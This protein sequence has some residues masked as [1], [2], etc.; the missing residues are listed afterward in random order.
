TMVGL[1][2]LA[3]LL[4]GVELVLVAR[5]ADL[6]RHEQQIQQILKEK[7][8]LA[9]DYARLLQGAGSGKSYIEHYSDFLRSIGQDPITLMAQVPSPVPSEDIPVY[10]VP[11][12]LPTGMPPIPT[13][14]TATPTVVSVPITVAWGA[15]L[16]IDQ[17]PVAV[18]PY[19][20]F[21]LDT[22]TPDARF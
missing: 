14:A 12:P 16:R 13:P 15:N 5:Q 6:S 20:V 4:F 18:D 2:W 22:V 19:S 7:E 17:V 21:V 11:T 1:V 10:D 9:A 3:V 8:V